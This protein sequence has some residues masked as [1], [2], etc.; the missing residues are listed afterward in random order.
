MR[1]RCC[2][3]LPP[4]CHRVEPF[5]CHTETCKDGA[6]RRI[7]QGG[8]AGRDPHDRRDEQRP[9]PDTRIWIFAVRRNHRD[10]AEVLRVTGGGDGAGQFGFRRHDMATKEKTLDD[11]FYET[12]K[13]VYFAEKKSGTRTMR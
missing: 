1:T 7:F 11:A 3:Q 6:R 2:L 13:D 9:P 4:A 5:G 10:E 12:L 8:T